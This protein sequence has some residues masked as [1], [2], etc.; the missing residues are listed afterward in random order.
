MHVAGII[1]EYNPFHNGHLFHLNETFRMGATHVVAVMSGN[2]TQRGEPA[3]IS[4]FERARMAAAHGADLVIELPL[5]YATASS[6]R[7]AF[8]AVSVLDTLGVV[9][10]LS[11]ASESGDIEK[12][13]SALDAVSDARVIRRLKQLVEIGENYPSA[14]SKAVEVFYP[15]TASLIHKPNNIL[16]VDYL[17]ALKKTGSRIYPVTVKRK[18]AEHDSDNESEG[19]ASAGRIRELVRERGYFSDFVPQECELSLLDLDVSGG[20]SEGMPRI[21]SAVLMK[22]RGLSREDMNRLP[23]A[24]TGL[25]DRLYNVSRE[26]DTIE[27]L[28]NSA[29]TKRYT[30]SRIKRAV[31][32][33]LLDI[34]GEDYIPP[35]YIRL[36]AIGPNGG[37]ILR[38]MK[39]KCAL[40]V[41]GSATELSKLGGLAAKMISKEC[42]ATDIFNLTLRKRKPAGE[43]FTSK[44]YTV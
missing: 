6:E 34:T 7:F 36:L 19:I 32:A 15:E 17:K 23:D 20:I 33:A 11:F 18:G 12:L 14:R 4:K 41:S 3:I 37:D 26:A 1:A 25:G 21:E 8:G 13:S 38:A 10:L 24:S 22:L 39:R 43:D 2:F 30:M 42:A 44:L 16:G 9:E 35:S 31:A 5:A 29:K 27:T 28:Y 40:P